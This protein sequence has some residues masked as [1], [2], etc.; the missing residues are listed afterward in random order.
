MEKVPILPLQKRRNFHVTKNSIQTNGARNVKLFF[1][2]LDIVTILQKKLVPLDQF[3][4]KILIF[5]CL[6]IIF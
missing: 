3:L 5:I 2:K 1:N 4:W 6:Q